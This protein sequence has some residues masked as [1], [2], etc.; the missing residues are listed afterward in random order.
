MVAAAVL[1]VAV[2]A[3]GGSGAAGTSGSTSLATVKVERRDLVERDTE[4]GTLGYADP[5]P[6]VNRTSGTITWL[7]AP[8]RVIH[9][10]HTLF[11]VDDQPIVLLNGATPAYR[12]LQAGVSD[13]PDVRELERNLHALGYDTG[14]PMTVNGT[15]DGATTAAVERWQTAHGLSVTGS[16]PLGGVVFQ[17]GTARRVS[18]VQATLGG[19]GSAGGSGSGSGTAG[20]AGASYGG[21]ARL[22]QADLRTT[23]QSEPAGPAALA[24]I[25]SQST[26]GCPAPGTSGGTPTDGGAPTTPCP[27]TKSSPKPAKTKPKQKT[28]TGR[29]TPT[30][31][32]GPASSGAAAAA[33]GRSG[34]GSASGS[35]ASAGGGSAAAA[36][37]GTATTVMTT[38]ATRQEVTVA[39]DTGK[40]SVAKVGARVTVQMPAGSFVHGRIVSVGKVATAATSSS[41]GSGG[42]GGS[43]TSSSATIPVSIRLNRT[44]AG[45]LDQAP[46]SV[47]FEQS[48]ARDVLAVPVTAL[49]AQPGGRFAVEVVEGGTR[50]LL[51]VSPGVYTSGYVQLSGAGLRPGMLVTNAAD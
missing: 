47:S 35:A 48:R 30:G 40:Q 17:P 20:T 7:P 21:G 27:T 26:T 28:T 3:G 29:A 23:G 46:V 36:S 14:A 16:I 19:T 25:V 37:G 50:R 2:T 5:R 45:G 32:R 18:A 33:V 6:V 15:W 38:T 41:G 34:G 31:S 11:K 42:S 1:I 4:T 39:L 10:D 22:V 44:S 24:A 13:G 51:A 49:I 9:I 12:A 8:G 43:S